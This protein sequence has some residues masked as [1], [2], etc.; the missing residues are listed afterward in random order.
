MKPSDIITIRSAVDWRWLNKKNSYLEACYSSLSNIV[1]FT[2]I[3]ILIVLNCSILID[4][5]WEWRI[6]ELIEGILGW[7]KLSNQENILSTEK[8]IFIIF[9][10][11]VQW[12]CDRVNDVRFDSILF[13]TPTF[14]LVCSEEISVFFK[15]HWVIIL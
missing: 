10:R 6:I 5:N 2:W 4:F 15:L 1:S 3:S 14:L 7:D 11:Y 13:K 8:T 9:Y 12:H